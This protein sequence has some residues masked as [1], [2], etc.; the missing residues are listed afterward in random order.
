MRC[1]THS[2]ATLYPS[3]VSKETPLLS[4]WRDVVEG[5]SSLCCNQP[6]SEKPSAQSNVLNTIATT[7]GRYRTK[8]L[9]ITGEASVSELVCRLFYKWIFVIYTSPSQKIQMQ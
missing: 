7:N 1:S 6:S 4:T 2:K 5:F 3:S 9:L 8:I